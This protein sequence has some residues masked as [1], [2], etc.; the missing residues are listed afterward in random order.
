MVDGPNKET[1]STETETDADA[2]FVAASNLDVANRLPNDEIQPEPEPAQRAANPY[3]STPYSNVYGS[4][5]LNDS[6]V[7]RSNDPNSTSN[8]GTDN[9]PLNERVQT[10]L[11]PELTAIAMENGQEPQ[12]TDSNSN[13]S[14]TGTAS[15]FSKLSQV[16]NQ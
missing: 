12:S 10:P 14:N 13:N 6:N 8:R 11:E 7:H 16:E 4:D 9:A 1:E 5:P 2:E 3:S 15:G